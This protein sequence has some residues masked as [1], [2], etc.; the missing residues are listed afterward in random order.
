MSL[1]CIGTVGRLT[2]RKTFT[3][4]PFETFQEKFLN[5]A[6]EAI[7]AMMNTQVEAASAAGVESHRVAI[8]PTISK[9]FTT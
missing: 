8:G 2:D 4:W 9:M 3:A 6:K 7:G 1:S 5:D